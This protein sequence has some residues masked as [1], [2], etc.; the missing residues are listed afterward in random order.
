M[1]R[2]LSSCLYPVRDTLHTVLGFARK[3]Y[4]RSLSTPLGGSPHSTCGYFAIYA[5]L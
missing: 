3:L 5:A 2:R 1:E 4:I